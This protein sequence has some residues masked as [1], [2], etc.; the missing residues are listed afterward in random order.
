MTIPIGPDLTPTVPCLYTTVRS[1]ASSQMYFGFLGKHG[2]SLAAGAQYTVPGNLATVL[3]TQGSRRKFE[4][5]ER[6]I[7]GFTAEDGSTIN[8]T[9]VLVSTPAPLFYD[10]VLEQTKTIQISNGVVRRADP[11]TGAYSSTGD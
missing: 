5:L 1:L 8:P 3:A 4:G 10:P 7:N 6:A 9:L 11:C 2:V